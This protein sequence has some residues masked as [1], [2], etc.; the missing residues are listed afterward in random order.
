[1]A[2]QRGVT[3]KIGNAVATRTHGPV[4]VAKRRGAGRAGRRDREVRRPL[5]PQ[6]ADLAVERVAECL[7]ETERDGNVTVVDEAVEFVS[8]ICRQYVGAAAR[9]DLFVRVGLVE[10]Q[11]GVDVHSG[12]S[13]AEALL[14]S[15][16]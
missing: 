8:L 15:A 14:R 5:L 1:I 10:P 11:V 7:V 9:L 4:V 6:R 13:S 16:R 12:S 3:V 2:S